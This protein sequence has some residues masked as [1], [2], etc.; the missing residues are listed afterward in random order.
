[1]LSKGT[2]VVILTFILPV[3][4]LGQDAPTGF[5]VNS[6]PAGAEVVL[7]GDI[8]VAGVSPV[9]FTQPLE[10]RYKLKVVKPGYETSKSAVY[11]EIGKPMSLTVELKPKTR[12]KALARSVFI[13]GWGQAYTGQKFKGAA[14]FVL[15]A[16]AGASF[17]IADA[18]FDD[19][20]V[21]Y[22]NLLSQ[23]NQASTFEEKQQL[24]PGLASARKD[25]YDAET[26]KRITIG[27]TIAVW[28]LNLLDLFFFFPEES[29]SLVINSLSI[30]PDI[31]RGG[32][33]I[34]LCHR[35]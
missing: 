28:S 14:L 34:V 18:D 12:F 8:T 30:K 24:Y 21:R 2:L 31:E 17:L 25:A 19:R 27:A 35:F 3:S 33:Q 9:R 11:L 5:T 29:G 26:L 1:M 32:A 22:D 13:P 7:T 16:G 6:N 20:T 23:Y 4:M 15:A 10:G